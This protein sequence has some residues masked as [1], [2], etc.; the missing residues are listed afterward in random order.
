[1]V[2]GASDGVTEDFLVA[3]DAVDMGAELREER[4]WDGRGA[5]FGGEYDVDNVLDV[6]RASGAPPALRAPH[7]SR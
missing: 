3:A 7:F 6:G 2:G 5:V 4:G 1:M